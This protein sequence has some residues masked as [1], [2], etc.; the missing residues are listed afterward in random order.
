MMRR[1]RW[2]GRGLGYHWAK[3]ANTARISSHVAEAARVA[4]TRHRRD[5]N[6]IRH[7]ARS[8]AATALSERIV[9][10]VQLREKHNRLASTSGR[11][12]VDVEY[13]AR[14]KAVIVVVV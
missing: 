9:L 7:I 2:V 6:C 4:R 8:L 13:F 1:V 10:T 14:E 11:V 5:G 3:L 12:V